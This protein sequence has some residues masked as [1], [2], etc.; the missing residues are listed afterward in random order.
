MSGHLRSAARLTG[1]AA[2]LL[3]TG[4]LLY[5]L[6]SDDVRVPLTS[7]TDLRTWLADTPPPTLAI[8]VVRLAAL[9]GV[10][11]L[12][13]ATALAVAAGVIRA[14]PLEAAAQGLTPAV[15]RRMATGGGGVG[16]ALGTALGS[17][18]SP[19]VAPHPIIATGALGPTDT[20]APDAAPHNAH[21]ATMIRYDPHI[22]TMTRTADPPAPRPA[23]TSA[24]SGPEE[25]GATPGPGNSSPGPIFPT[26]ST[27]HPT[28]PTAP[29][30]TAPPPPAADAASTRATADAA[31]NPTA[32]GGAPSPT[33]IDTAPIPV[34]SNGSQNAASANSAP[35]AAAAERA[36]N[37]AATDSAPAPTPSAANAV[38]AEGAPDP[39][40][41]RGAPSPTAA[42]GGS[43]PIGLARIGRAADTP[44]PSPPA[45]PDDRGPTGTAVPPPLTA[46]MIRVD[47]SPAPEVGSGVAP[48]PQPGNTW[49]VGPGDS[50]WS[51]AEDVLASD[52]DSPPGERDVGRYWR[53]LIDANR[54]RLVDA[55]NPDLLLPGQ[56]LVLPP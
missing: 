1:W 18:P 13:A 50:F 28:A 56:E 42:D 53:R 26:S 25:T 12:L 35:H 6:G 32:T 33:P 8:A 43:L 5:S 23:A 10:A 9:A 34:A 49:V 44:G 11:Y 29:T 38:A 3:V 47:G 24:R 31:P 54:D 22:A 46:T 40:P 20:Y 39:A 14:K 2:G 36:P 51:I 48:L 27:P 45:G 4:R 17:I 7:L 15:V 41:A 55:G 19:G 30:P 52:G 21:I 37:A 16:L